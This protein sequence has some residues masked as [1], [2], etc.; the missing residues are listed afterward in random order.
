[1]AMEK[2]LID[3]AEYQQKVLDYIYSEEIDEAFG[4]TM[5]K[6]LPESDIYKQAMIYGMT[7]AAM[8]TSRCEPIVIEE[9]PKGHWE[10]LDECSNQ[11]VYCSVCSKK[12]YRT[13][14]ANQKVKSK[15]CPNCGSRME[16]V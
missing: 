3:S 11:G 16:D 4:A 14:Y 12:V 5:F 8:V 6:N 10:I 1:M 9:R 2:L 7:I 15:Y 13:E